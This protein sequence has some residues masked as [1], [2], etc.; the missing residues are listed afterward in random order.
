[1]QHW[2]VIGEAM[3][4]GHMYRD[5]FDPLA[6]LAATTYWL[7]TAIFGKSVLALHILGTLLLVIQAIIFNNLTINNKVFEQNTYL[8]ALMFVVLSSVHYSLSAFSPAQL[9]MTFILLAFGKLLSHVEFR[10]KR[11]E[12]IMSIGLLL[13]MGVL[14][15]LP[16]ILFLPIVII[17]LLLFT[18]TLRKRYAILCISALIPFS[19]V[20]V[21]Y[22]IVLGDIGY[23]MANLIVPSL[24]VDFAVFKK[25]GE[26]IDLFVAVLLFL[27]TGFIT[28]PKQRRLNNYQNRLARLFF[29][30]GLLA[31]FILIFAPTN[32]TT[33]LIIIVPSAAYFSTHLFFLLKRPML[34]LF[35]SLLFMASI[36]FTSYDSEFQFAGVVDKI[37]TK[38][39]L[40]PVLE[41]I[42]K[43]K[44]LMVLGNKPQIYAEGV[45]A[46]PFYDWQLAQ[47]VV[48]QLNYYDNL[49]FIKESIDRFKPEIIIDYEFLWRK[50]ED[51]I[52]ELGEEYEQVRPFV[53]K[54]K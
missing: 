1:M 37:D 20:L 3:K 47:P 52:P 39:S 49:I 11:D 33:G 46:T 17:I 24:S 29:L 23:F 5:I 54:R 32:I 19:I 7:V 6:P 28:M 26:H 27:L 14:F 12:Q 45:L 34:E 38:I 30:M 25:I 22:W 35:V 53:W 43:D 4:T 2:L 13:G 40:A 50:L 41:E 44:K 48:S 15:Y 9:G 18:N 10:A 42:V 51:R 36:L 31:M 21:Y 16:N 8:P